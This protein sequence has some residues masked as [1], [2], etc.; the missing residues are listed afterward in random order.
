MNAALSFLYF[1]LCI[2]IVVVVPTL[3]APF[4]E[5]YGV[6]SRFDTSKAVLLCTAVALLV[7]LIVYKQERHGAFLLRLFMGALVVRML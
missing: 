2:F 3:V 7:G 6:V 5:E 1:G 4:T